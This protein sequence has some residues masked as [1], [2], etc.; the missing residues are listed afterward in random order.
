MEIQDKFYVKNLKCVRD[1]LKFCLCELRDY[2]YNACDE[3]RKKCKMYS[4]GT[5]YSK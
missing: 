5:R 3:I 1:F 2:D 4:I